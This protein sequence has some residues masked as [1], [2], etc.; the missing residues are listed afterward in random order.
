MPQW[1]VAI[2]AMVP[3]LIWSFMSRLQGHSLVKMSI[4]YDIIAISVWNVVFALWGEAFTGKQILALGLHLA[5]I[6]LVV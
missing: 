4:L 5:A 1:S 2:S 6:L 3:A